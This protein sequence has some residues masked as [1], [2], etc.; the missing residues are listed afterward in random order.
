MQDI[1]AVQERVQDVERTNGRL[2]V[3][4]E[5]MER[6][7]SLVQDRV[8]SN[9]IALQRHGYLGRSSDRFA[10]SRS[11]ERPEPAPESHYHQAREHSGYQADPSMQ[12]RMDQRGVGRIPLS[13]QQS[14]RV[15]FHGNRESAQPDPQAGTEGPGED[16]SHQEELIITNAELE[17]RYG[18]SRGSSRRT[19]SSS[20]SS[21]GETSSSSGP[22]APVTSERLPT[23]EELEAGEDLEGSNSD[24][25]NESKRSEKT[26]SLAG[27]SHDEL[28]EVYQ[29]SLSQYRAGDYGDAL[30]GFTSFLEAG[31]RANYIDNALYWIGECHYGLGEYTT[32]VEHFQRILDELPAADKVPDAMLKMSL[33]YEQMGK[34]QQALDL[35]HELVEKYPNSNPGRL[36]QERLDERGEA[37]N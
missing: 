8:E 10:R 17:A 35:L 32:S 37:E 12:Q 5:E 26:G 9:R 4:V 33:A 14:G 34:P 20:T 7:V 30:V 15:E 11:S 29:D 25:S 16:E 24:D 27:A 6:Q 31:P 23:S 18:P 1:A 22:H 21:S 36:G 19:H 2:M 28:L 13:N 3:R